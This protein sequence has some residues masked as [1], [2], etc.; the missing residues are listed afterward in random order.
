MKTTRDTSRKLIHDFTRFLMMRNAYIK[1]MRNIKGELYSDLPSLL[2]MM[3]KRG[4]G[5]KDMRL[6]M[7]L[8]AFRWMGTKEGH[9]FWS[10]LNE[11]W[12][13]QNKEK[14]KLKLSE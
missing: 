1:F 3:T 11:E 7:L 5:K 12:V 9:G 14:T 4:Y 6:S 13:D 10:M 2:R 8:F